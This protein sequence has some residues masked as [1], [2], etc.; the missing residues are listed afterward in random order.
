LLKADII[1]PIHDSTWVSPIHIVPKKEGMTV[2]KNEN[3][4]LIFT[5]I[6]TEYHMCIDYRKLNKATR[7]DHFP[8]P[9][10]DQMLE[11]FA[12]NSYFC[13]LDGYSSSFKSLSIVVTKKRLLLLILVVYILIGEYHLGCVM[14]LLHFNVV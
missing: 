11:R 8:I 1:Y 14:P 4:E 9:F 6:I 13:C 3:N 7:K 5:R 12:K 2:A 10:I